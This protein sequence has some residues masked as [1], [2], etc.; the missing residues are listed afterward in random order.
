ML[1]KGAVFS[2]WKVSMCVCFADNFGF[3]LKYMGRV[4]YNYFDVHKDKDDYEQ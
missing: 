1:T 2:E 3:L 4:S